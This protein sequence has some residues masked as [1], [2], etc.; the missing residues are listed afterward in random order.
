MQKF[1]V[2]LDKDDRAEYYK[3]LSQKILAHY[4]EKYVVDGEITE[5]S[6]TAYLLPLYFDM[7]EGEIKA[8]TIKNLETKITQ[9]NYTLSTGFVG[10]GVLCQ[11][12]AKVGLN[13]LA[14]DLLLQDND[15][16][17]LYSVKQGA[18]TIWERWNSYTKA[19]GFG[20]VK[21]NSFNHYA[22]GAVAEW[23]Y[24]TMAGIRP[25]T[26]DGGFDDGFVLA[27]MPD[28]K[29]RITSAKASYRGIVSEWHYE[30]S[31]FVWHVVIPDGTARVEFPLASGQK[32]VTVNDIEFTQKQLGGEIKNSKMTF[33][34][35]AGEY[36][37]K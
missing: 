22:Y 35:S 11:T 9:N 32:T 29:K 19:T 1:S 15:P 18:T 16:S 7:L 20:D 33:N 37:I 2:L 3:D 25:N 24:S 12:L 5:K 10:T 26:D 8:K 31:Q 6:Q 28:S 17:W 21:M 27:P 34:L 4:F 36:V 14:Y 13:D 30:D 23:M